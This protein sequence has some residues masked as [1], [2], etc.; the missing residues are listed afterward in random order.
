M[1]P[2]PL[3]S[4]NI[5]DPLFSHYC[6][7][8]AKQVIPFEW[9]IMNDAVPGA[10]R[11]HCIENFRIAAGESKGER[12]GFVFQDTDAY[13]WLE[14][15]AYCLEQGQAKEWE[16]KADA[17]IDLIVRAQKEDGYLDTYY[18][19]LHPEWQWKNLFSGHEMYC[20]GHLIEAA[21][22]YYRATGK[23]KLLKA[24]ARFA[25]HIYKRFYVDKTPG[26]PGH[27]ELELALIKLYRVTGEEKYLQLAHYFLTVRGQSPNYMEAE[28]KRNADAGMPFYRDPDMSYEQAHIPPVEQETVEGHSVRMMYMC[29]AMADTAAACGDEKLAAACVTLWKNMTEKRMYITGGI[30]S[31]PWGERFTTDYDLPNDRMYCESCASIGLMMFG[32]RMTAMTGDAS[33]YDAVERALCNTVLGGISQKGDSFFYVNPLEVW[34]EGCRKNTTLADVAPVRQTWFPC[35]CCPPNIARTLA[36]LSQYIYACDEK[37]IFV[38]MPVSSEAEMELGD[39]KLS[40]SLQNDWMQTGKLHL[41]CRNSAN[42]PAFVRV[43]LPWYVKDPGIGPAFMEKGYAVFTVPAASDN[44]WVITGSVKPEFTAACDLVR[45]DAG[46]TA[47]TFGPFVYCLE[48]ADNGTELPSLFADIRSVQ[49]LPADERLAGE[50]P[51]LSFR[52]KKLRSGVDGLYGAPRF[53]W[54]EKAL[55]AVPYCL[56]NNREPG[57]MLV[58][59]NV[60]FGE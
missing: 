23:D 51:V 18:T 4:V 5:T 16:E 59:I 14:A 31:S 45:F 39:G 1:L 25:D 17:L 41:I 32:Q 48:E 9:A 53:T 52:G 21:V 50:L 7:L 24:A 34:P 58:W 44:E 38:Q 30:G 42:V 19:A 15:V 37:G 57:E 55:K 40:L 10:E 49:A 43:R 56:W 6:S 33:Y 27:Q 54:E 26:Y 28:Q 35:A 3:R 13:K 12:Y 11:S 8:I 47:L 36:S 60:L 29:S 22:A 2:L 20:C 46:K